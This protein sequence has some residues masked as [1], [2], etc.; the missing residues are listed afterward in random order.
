MASAPTFLAA[1]VD[2]WMQNQSYRDGMRMTPIPRVIDELRQPVV[3]PRFRSVWRFGLKSKNCTSRS[4]WQIIRSR[5]PYADYE[6]TA[7]QLDMYTQNE[8]RRQ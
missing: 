6:V 4:Y 3:G 8:L 5:V 7:E 2:V 1:T